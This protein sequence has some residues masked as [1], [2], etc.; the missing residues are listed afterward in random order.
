MTCKYSGNG[1]R[2]IAISVASYHFRLHL[3]NR[4]FSK[5]FFYI[6]N[7]NVAVRKDKS[8]MRITDNRVKNNTNVP[9]YKTHNSKSLDNRQA[10]KKIQ[11]Q[12]VYRTVSIDFGTKCT[13]EEYSRICLFG[14]W[15]TPVLKI[16]S[17]FGSLIIFFD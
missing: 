5:V 13:D 3:N 9:I 10:L 12:I 4:W 1:F 14:C 8:L 7:M 11:I 2:F 6:K 15:R 17:S 16:A